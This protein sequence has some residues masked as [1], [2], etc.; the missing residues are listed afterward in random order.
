MPDLFSQEDLM[1]KL[2]T[3]KSALCISAA[4]VS[5]SVFGDQLK[6][7]ADDEPQESVQFSR[8]S[9]VPRQTT[10]PGTS[11]GFDVPPESAFPTDKFG[12]EGKTLPSKI[13]L[14][15]DLT[16]RRLRITGGRHRAHRSHR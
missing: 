13:E 2:T 3:I 4:I 8:L 1:G 6:P 12:R 14:E 9:D 16:M 10:A 15:I 11:H 7:K 5:T